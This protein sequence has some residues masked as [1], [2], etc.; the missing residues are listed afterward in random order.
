MNGWMHLVVSSG[1]WMNAISRR[2][3][4]DTLRRGDCMY[5]LSRCDWRDALSRECW[6]GG[7]VM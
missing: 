3:R 7:C 2:G 6:L 4:I 1:G 5:A